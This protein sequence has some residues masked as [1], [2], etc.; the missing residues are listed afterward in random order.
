MKHKIMAL[1]AAFG[2]ALLCGCGK[3]DTHTGFDTG[4]ESG[5]PPDSESNTG[6]TGSKP[7]V[8]A[9]FVG[10]Y[11]EHPLTFLTSENEIRALIDAQPNFKCSDALNINIPESASVYE[12]STYGVHVPQF[13]YPSSQFINDFEALYEY[14]FPDREIDMD[15]L[16]YRTYL[17]YDKEKSDYIEE[18]G[19]VKDLTTL[20]D[21]TDLIYDEMPERTETWNS[22]VYISIFLWRS[23]V[24][25]VL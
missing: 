22:P 11:P 3:N 24:V 20:S 21:I 6:G 8:F 12:Y 14:M 13:N 4:P 15:F 17:G 19:Y 2:L 23:A 5:S 25:M 1:T 9:N 7:P 10:E 18:K 16:K